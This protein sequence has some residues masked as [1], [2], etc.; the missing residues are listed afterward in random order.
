MRST[1]YFLSLII[2]STHLVGVANLQAEDRGMLANPQSMDETLPSGPDAREAAN[3]REGTEEVAGHTRSMDEK[4]SSSPTAQGQSSRPESL[5]ITRQIRKE[6]MEQ[7]G[8]ST[9]AKNVKVITDE[10]GA[11]TLRGPVKNTAERDQLEQIARNS[12]QGGQVNNQLVVKSE[13]KTKGAAH[14]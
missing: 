3:V 8:L 11:V 2:S 12:A 7:R 9:A 14:G 5:Q 10:N 1:P 6:I 13:E 4:R